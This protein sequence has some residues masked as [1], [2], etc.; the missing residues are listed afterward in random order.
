MKR[1][2]KTVRRVRVDEEREEITS[3]VHLKDQKWCE[4]CYET[5]GQ[6]LRYEDNTTVSR[7]DPIDDMKPVKRIHTNNDTTC[8]SCE[9]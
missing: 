2:G 1:K 7:K 5:Q 9:G 3:W 4:Q 6:Y 8:H